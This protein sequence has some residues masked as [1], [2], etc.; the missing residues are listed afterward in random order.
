MDLDSMYNKNMNNEDLQS[1]I[2]AFDDFMKHFETE[3]LYY[4]G[5]MVYENHRAEARRIQEQE[6]ESKA[7]ELEVT[8]DYYMAEFM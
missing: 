6:I 2:Q 1:F 5:R 3:E 7:A 4:E 8:C